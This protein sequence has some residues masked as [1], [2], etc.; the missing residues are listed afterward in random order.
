M[1][2][3]T[4]ESVSALHGGRGWLQEEKEINDGVQVKDRLA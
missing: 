2:K 1:T 4:P 3:W